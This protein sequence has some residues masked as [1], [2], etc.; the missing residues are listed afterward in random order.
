MSKERLGKRYQQDQIYLRLTKAKILIGYSVA[1]I[2][3]GRQSNLN[4]EQ[5]CTTCGL[6]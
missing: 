4:V 3:T 6:Q 2:K 1:I 5:R